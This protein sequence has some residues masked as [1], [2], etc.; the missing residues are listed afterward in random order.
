MSNDR[1]SRRALWLLL[2]AGRGEGLTIRYQRPVEQDERNPVAQD[3]RR[4]TA[5]K[6]GF[7][8]SSDI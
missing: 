3:T 7:H 5:G 6:L 2:P 4:A 1:N 8:D